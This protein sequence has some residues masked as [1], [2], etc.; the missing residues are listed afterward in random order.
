MSNQYPGPNQPYG[1]QPYQGQPYPGPYQQGPAP[2]QPP[3]SPKKGMPAWAIVLIIMGGIFVF[4]IFLGALVGGD[5]SSSDAKKSSTVSEAP[6][7]APVKKDDGK[8]AARPADKP[9]E[10]P[11]EPA[12]VQITAKKTAFKPS[13]LHDGGDFTSVQVTITNNSDEKIDVNPLYFS[14]TATDGSK[15]NAELGED[16]NQMDVMDLAPGEKTTGV[17]TGEGKFTAKYVTYTDG[18]FGDD[19][20]GN[21]S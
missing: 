13:I 16:E 18:M 8:P 5:D 15:R 3:Q 6:K 11:A 21:V 7:D 19:V 17:I 9:A 2:Y 14:I 4:L 20:R 1:R 12:P 10:K